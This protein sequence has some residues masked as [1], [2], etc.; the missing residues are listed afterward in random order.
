MRSDCYDKK[1]DV[2]YPCAKEVKINF[3]EIQGIARA[4]KMGQAKSVAVRLCEAEVRQRSPKL[5]G[6]TLFDSPDFRCRVVK[7]QYCPTFKATAAQKKAKQKLKDERRR[8]TDPELER[9]YGPGSD[10][11]SGNQNCIDTRGRRP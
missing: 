7:E 4:P 11:P 2:W 10:C 9:R 6:F 1:K 8:K 3:S 5:G